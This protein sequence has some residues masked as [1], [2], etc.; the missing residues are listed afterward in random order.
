M[1]VYFEGKET[2]VKII[3]TD[4]MIAD[5]KADKIVYMTDGNLTISLLYKGDGIQYADFG[6]GPKSY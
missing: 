5:L 3:I 2:I 1:D 6:T 4:Q